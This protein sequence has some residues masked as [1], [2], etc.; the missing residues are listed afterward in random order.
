MLLKILWNCILSW[1]NSIPPT[2]E[3]LFTGS[4]DEIEHSKRIFTLIVQGFDYH[5]KIVT[6]YYPDF[7]FQHYF[8]SESQTIWNSDV[9]MVEILKEF[10]KVLN[11]GTSSEFS[12]NSKFWASIIFQLYLVPYEF[13]KANRK[14]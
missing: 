13:E 4:S 10:V 8:F 11:N 3:P 2:I 9:M 12:E 14:N 1:R 5:F 7:S 6:D